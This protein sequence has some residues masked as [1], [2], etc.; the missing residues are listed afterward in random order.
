VVATLNNLYREIASD[1]FAR[2][3]SLNP[4]EGPD[5]E[6]RLDV[7]DALDTGRCVCYYPKDTS[8]IAIAVG[9]AL[10]SKFFE[11]SFVRGDRERAFIYVCDEFQRF[12]TNDPTS[13]EQSF[14]DRCRAFR[15]ICVLATQSVASLKYALASDGSDAGD[16]ASL[17][18]IMNNTG[19]QALLPQHRSGHAEAARSL[20]PMPYIQNKPHLT[21]VR[22]VSTLG[23]GECYY[24]LSSGEW[25]RQRVRLP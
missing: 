15:G 2:Y 5:P 7:L 9:K 12:I 11:V 14:L 16:Q 23:V 3:V 18:V 24:L 1:Q 4:F 6:R 17:D 22:P 13:G 21:D 10:K 8:V 25:G 19:H 20:I